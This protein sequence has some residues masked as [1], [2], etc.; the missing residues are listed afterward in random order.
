MGTKTTVDELNALLRDELIAIETYEKALAGRSAFSGKTELSRCQMSHERRAGILR[1]QVL[2]LGGAPV[3]SSG[4]RGVVARA[5]E[6]GAAAIG[7]GVAIR[8]LE[9]W[10]D[11][12]LKDYLARSESLDSTSR[13]LLA[14]KLLPEQVETYRVVSDLKR[15]LQAD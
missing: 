1:E 14:T 13:H 9:E 10:E 5:I 11:R 3:E 8:A 6:S 12:G 7:D 2:L 4:V 15:R